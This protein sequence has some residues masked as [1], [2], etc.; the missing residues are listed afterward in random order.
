M[1][2]REHE[3]DSSLPPAR[4]QKRTATTSAAAT[5]SSAQAGPSRTQQQQVR[6]GSAS[7]S[8]GTAPRRSHTTTAAGDAGIGASSSRAGASTSRYGS[9][10]GAGSGSA[11]RAKAEPSRPSLSNSNGHAAAASAT[12]GKGA[13][14]KFWRNDRCMRA[15]ALAAI[16]DVT[17]VLTIARLNSVAYGAAMGVFLERI[18]ISKG[19]LPG[20]YKLLNKKRYLAQC[21]KELVVSDNWPYRDVWLAP[22]TSVASSFAQFWPS[23]LPFGQLAEI[24]N[25]V[26][27]RRDQN[28]ELRID[29]ALDFWCTKALYEVCRAQRAC[30]AR[31]RAIRITGTSPFYL[32]PS[33]VKPEEKATFLQHFEGVM[34]ASL[35]SIVRMSDQLDLFQILPRE[36]T[37]MVVTIPATVPMSLADHQ[38][39]VRTVKLT[40]FPEHRYALL[41]FAKHYWNSLSSLSINFVDADQY[42]YEMKEFDIML[43][44]KWLDLTEL[45]ISFWGADS[46]VLRWSWSHPR[47]KILDADMS[48]TVEDRIVKFVHDHPSIEHLSLHSDQRTKRPTKYPPKLRSCA[49]VLGATS[50]DPFA[51]AVESDAPYVTALLKGRTWKQ[52]LDL[53][54]WTEKL[55]N[56][57][58][59]DLVIDVAQFTTMCGFFGRDNARHFASLLEICVICNKF[60]MDGSKRFQS[61]LDFLAYAL[62]HF[63]FL[64][65]VQVVALNSFNEALDKEDVRHRLFTLAPTL[66]AAAWLTTSEEAQIFSVEHIPQLHPNSAALRPV[67]PFLAGFSRL[68]CGQEERGWPFDYSFFLHSPDGR[69]VPRSP[70]VSFPG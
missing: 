50:K 47:L 13:Q 15:L 26:C 38:Q 67:S 16:P 30:A 17:T 59:L 7:T 60:E 55:S 52:D 66:R 8:N 14:A 39:D 44:R 61:G 28:V 68:D 48:K 65:R 51:A 45:R 31:I 36:E 64:P 21:V 62:E 53:V 35:D 41:A 43:G 49:I 25:W 6:D 32:P 24:F 3:E 46:D 29:I 18:E 40:I 33:T 63:R 58:A 56:L 22:S 69:A 5:T 54:P 57:T 27:P 34:W 1:V 19:S 4:S 9:T 12:G 11:P 23:L 2:K 42:P 20:I 10:S 70:L 37:K